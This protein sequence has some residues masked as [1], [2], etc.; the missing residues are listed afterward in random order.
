M[1]Q[2]LK[3]V[4]QENEP[5]FHIRRGK[6]TLSQMLAFVKVSFSEINSFIILFLFAIYYSSCRWGMQTYDLDL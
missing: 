5:L 2:P 1:Y 3:L 6:S 4:S